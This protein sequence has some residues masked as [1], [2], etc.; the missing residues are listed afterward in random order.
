MNP[1]SG[2]GQV[3]AVTPGTP[4]TDIQKE[5]IKIVTE[6]VSHPGDRLGAIEQIK[7]D[8]AF[9]SQ[10]VQKNKTLGGCAIF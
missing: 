9:A 10:L 3:R 8:P 7:V 2:F 4:L 5:A 6:N 1:A